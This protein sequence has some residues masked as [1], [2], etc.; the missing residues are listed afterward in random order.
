M[1]VNTN[2][3]GRNSGVRS[4]GGGV[5]DRTAFMP[6]TREDSNT[7]ASS[8]GNA[9]R[10]WEHTVGGAN[11]RARVLS[12]PVSAPRY[13]GSTPAPGTTNT[14]G[15][16]PTN[17]PVK[18]DP[19]RRNASDYDNVINQFAVAHNPRYTPR[20]GN[21][22]CNI[23][24]WDVTRAMGAEVPH[25]VNASGTPVGVGQGRE[26]NANATNDWFHQHG[27]R[28]GWR[29]VSAEEAQRMA[30]AGHPSVASWKNPNG[31]GHIAIVRPGEINSRG[32]AIAQAG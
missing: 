24:V 17:P 29:Q 21:T 2:Y 20:G 4:N 30:N 25:W 28:H 3:A 7:A 6:P 12:Q 13:D 10:L 32:P 18:G 1:T 19:A 15:W 26:L 31:I 9:A 8:Q 5:D 27:A 16:I 11:A 22:Y 14:N 23:F